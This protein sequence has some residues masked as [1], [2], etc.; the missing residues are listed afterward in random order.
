[1]GVR[2]ADEVYEALA[3]GAEGI[4]SDRLSKSG[5]GSLSELKR[6]LAQLGIQIRP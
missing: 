3:G 2:S 4:Q 6:E 1:M 5:E